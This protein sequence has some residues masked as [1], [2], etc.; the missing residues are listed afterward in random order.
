MITLPQDSQR[1]LQVLAALGRWIRFPETRQMVEWLQGE[2][3]RLDTVNRREIEDIT[4]RQRQGAAQAIAELLR[5]AEEADTTAEKI[6]INKP[7]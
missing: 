5:M 4:Y 2:L 6:R 3:Q 1:K 7:K